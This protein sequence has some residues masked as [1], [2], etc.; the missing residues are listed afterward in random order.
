MSEENSLAE[1]HIKLQA[2]VNDKYGQQNFFRD[3][4]DQLIKQRH[5]KG[6]T[7]RKGITIDAVSRILTGKTSLGVDLVPLFCELLHITPAQFF[8][9]DEEHE[10]SVLLDKLENQGSRIKALEIAFAEVIK[11]ANENGIYTGQDEEIANLKQQV[12]DQKAVID[13]MDELFKRIKG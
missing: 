4:L 9:M 8:G 6:I 5:R 3:A 11:I 12:E 1:N 13:Q 2:L 7:K 10:T